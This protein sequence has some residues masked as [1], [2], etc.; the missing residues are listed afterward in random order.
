MNTRSMNSTAGARQSLLAAMAVG[1]V[2]LVLG[3]V[4][5]TASAMPGM[6]GHPASPPDTTHA[7]STTPKPPQPGMSPL[8]K[9]PATPPD[10]STARKVKQL[11][12]MIRHRVFHDF[13][14]QIV[15]RLGEPFPIGDTEYS[16]T[17][18]QYVPDFAMDI[19]TGHV[20]LRTADAN[21]PAVRI[22]V[23][24]KGV[25]QDTTW[26]LLDMPPHFGRKSM[27][28]F[29]MI[30]IEYTSGKPLVAKQPV[31]QPVAKQPAAQPVAKPTAQPATQP[32]A[33]GGASK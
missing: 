3:L 23:K 8:P 30:K 13:A 10:L 21:N 7:K 20:I 22:V 31:A 19:K 5:V 4:A 29:Q 28:A 1:A 24:E 25:L 12:L 26:A 32:A 33:P 6:E 18:D 15:T 2:G 17:V 14:E 11:T 27:L 16:A 9:A